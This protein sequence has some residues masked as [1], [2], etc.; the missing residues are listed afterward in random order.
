MCTM[1]KYLSFFVVVFVAEIFFF[2]VG[3]FEGVLGVRSY[4]FYIYIFF[5]YVLMLCVYVCI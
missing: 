5:F 4:F 1:E 2:R 3:S